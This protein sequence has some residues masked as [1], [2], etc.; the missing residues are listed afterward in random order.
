MTVVGSIPV[1]FGFEVDD[2]HQSAITRAQT[3]P[4]PVDRGST[5]LPPSPRRPSKS[6][7]L[8]VGSRP[9]GRSCRSSPAMPPNATRA[10]LNGTKRL[11]SQTSMRQKVAQLQI[12]GSSDV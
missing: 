7:G 4:N 10:L 12:L 5:R 3:S 11:C 9:P 6:D 8:K 2:L 1:V